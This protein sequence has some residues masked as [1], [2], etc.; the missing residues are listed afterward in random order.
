MLLP[1]VLLTQQVGPEALVTYGAFV[2]LHVADHVAVEAAVGGERGVT[3]VALK[4][5]HSCW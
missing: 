3:N 1:H 2:G 5:L 4:W